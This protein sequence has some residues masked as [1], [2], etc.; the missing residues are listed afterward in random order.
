MPA[1]EH[2]ALNNAA[3]PISGLEEMENFA[4]D[5]SLVPTNTDVESR[6]SLIDHKPLA[7]QQVNQDLFD[8]IGMTNGNNNNTLQKPTENLFDLLGGGDYDGKGI[9][10]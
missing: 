4:T 8:L 10:F 2:N 1:I 3:M 6:M 9:H 5:V 7:Q